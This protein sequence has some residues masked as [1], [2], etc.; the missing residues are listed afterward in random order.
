MTF[1]VIQFANKPARFKGFLASV[2]LEIAPNTFVAPRFKRAALDRV[3]EVLRDWHAAAPEGY[4]I[5]LIG[6]SEPRGVPEIRTLGLPPRTILE[7]DEMLL[8]LRER[9]SPDTH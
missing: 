1:A 8:L 4:V 7:Q 5:A 6:S 3:W 9:S 2:M